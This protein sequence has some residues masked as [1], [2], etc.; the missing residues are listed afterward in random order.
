[1]LPADLIAEHGALVRVRGGVWTRTGEF[2]TSWKNTLQPILQLYADRLPGAFVEEKSHSLVWHYRAAD[3]EQARM[4]E[5]E[6][7]DHLTL[8]T[9]N[10]DLQVLRGSRVVELRPAGV[11]KGAACRAFAGRVDADFIF[12]AGD[13]WTDEDMFR[14][15]PP[16]AVTIRVGIVS[17]NAR[18]NLR[19]S[20]DVC[21]L[22]EAMAQAR[23]GGGRPDQEW[24]PGAVDPWPARLA[25]GKPPAM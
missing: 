11:T 14:A 12:A 17:T 16:F 3:P 5:N 19:D 24:E 20:R 7:T 18:F 13:D 25:D 1:M 10:V 4:L 23:S 8:F 15:L 9:A 21:G 22:L 2:D 6:L